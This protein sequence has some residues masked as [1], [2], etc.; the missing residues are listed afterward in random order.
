[1]LEE[2]ARRDPVGSWK[3]GQEAV[4]PGVEVEAAFLGE[5]QHDD[6]DEGL[7]G[8][9]DVPR[10]VGVDGPARRVDGR[11][12]GG[13]LGDRAVAIEQRDARADELTGGAVRLEDVADLLASASASELDV[14]TVIAE[15]RQ[16]DAT[17]RADTP[18]PTASTPTSAGSA[19]AHAGAPDAA[20]KAATIETTI[21]LRR[22]MWSPYS[23]I[24]WS[25]RWDPTNPDRQS[26]RG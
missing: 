14:D 21:T 18:T 6:G 7:G 2:L 9:A 19:D 20:G 26:S 1:M 3:V 24:S 22:L 11:R 12:A 25:S 16:L 13:D 4:D 5:L 8:A 10:H 23:P 17:G 15:M